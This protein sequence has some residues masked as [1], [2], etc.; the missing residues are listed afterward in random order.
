MNTTIPKSNHVKR[1]M[2]AFMVCFKRKSDYKLHNSNYLNSVRSGREDSDVR[3]HR[4]IQRCTIQRSAND[5]VPIG[6]NWPN[7]RNGHSS[8]KLNVYEPCTWK[9]RQNNR[10]VIIRFGR[11]VSPNL[12]SL[13]FIW[14]SQVFT[15]L[16]ATRWR[17]I[18]DKDYYYRMQ[19]LQGM[20]MWW[21]NKFGC[22]CVCV[23][24]WLYC[25]FVLCLVLMIDTLIPSIE[26]IN[27]I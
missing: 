23:Y 26:S 18:L 7:Q 9:V 13:M 3:W 6:N 2:N 24:V 20:W 22:V 1:P 4:R 14:A 25:V 21:W 12:K 19:Q 11:L 5:S 16:L 27:L 15:S 17:T 10:Y 8:T